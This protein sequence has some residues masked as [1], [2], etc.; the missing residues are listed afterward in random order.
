M[1]PLLGLRSSLVRRVGVWTSPRGLVRVF[2]VF[3]YGPFGQ[4][5]V[6][7]DVRLVIHRLLCGVRAMRESDYGCHPWGLCV[8]K[9]KQRRQPHVLLP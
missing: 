2:S 8:R 6:R 9:P 7:R 4:Y 5:Q 1:D 3:H